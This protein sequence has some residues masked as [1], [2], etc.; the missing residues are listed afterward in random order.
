MFAFSFVIK[1]L[2]TVF[3]F[4]STSAK[5]QSMSKVSIYTISNLW[6][7][8]EDTISDADDKGGNQISVV[9]K[10]NALPSNILTKFQPTEVHTL[11][12]R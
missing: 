10:G 8:T 5:F 7:G 4:R 9:L 2:L 6:N 11:C 12:N 1:A 3:A